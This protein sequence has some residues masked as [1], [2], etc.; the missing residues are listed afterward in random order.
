M[1]KKTGIPLLIKIVQD[2]T[3]LVQEG[4]DPD[5]LL[6]IAFSDMI[7]GETEAKEMTWEEKLNLVLPE[8][9]QIEDAVGFVQT[10]RGCMIPQYQ[11]QQNFQ[12]I[13]TVLAQNP[14][15]MPFENLQL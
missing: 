9:L 6:E 12:M 1:A 13:A 5:L 11:T 14:V 3:S 4:L 7:V 10:L 2:V 15:S 8:E